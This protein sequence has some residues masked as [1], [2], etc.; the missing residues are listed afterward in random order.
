MVCSTM[1]ANSM[2]VPRR[3][4]HMLWHESCHPSSQETAAWS[5]NAYGESRQKELWFMQTLRPY[6]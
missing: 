1:D 3:E 6:Q 2:A 5:N 4:A